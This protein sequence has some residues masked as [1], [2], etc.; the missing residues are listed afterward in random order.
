MELWPVGGT[1]KEEVL[2]AIL[3]VEKRGGLAGFGGARSR[4]RSHGQIDTAAL[5]D[6][7]QKTVDS[8]FRTRGASARHAEADAFRF[9]ISRT[10]AAGTETVEASEADV[11]AAIASCVKDEF[12]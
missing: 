2:M 10:T 8:L 11:P 5:S 3:H 4:I 1:T 6:D 9:R 12:V 7:D